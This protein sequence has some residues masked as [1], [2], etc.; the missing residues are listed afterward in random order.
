MF[1]AELHFNV[2]TASPH[3]GLNLRAPLRR[4]SFVLS[5]GTLWPDGAHRDDAYKPQGQD[6]DKR[7]QTSKSRRT[8][9]SA[10]LLRC[11]LFRHCE[12]VMNKS[13]EKRT[14]VR[15]IH[16]EKVPM[17]LE[18]WIK[19]LFVFP[20]MKGSGKQLLCGVRKPMCKGRVINWKNGAIFRHFHQLHLSCPPLTIHYCTVLLYSPQRCLR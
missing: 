9:L 6:S 10:S 5:P 7:I 19:D 2:S 11:P 8:R 13:S 18:G 3:W 4:R 1:W 16:S 12:P 14:T 20:H 17:S 15:Q